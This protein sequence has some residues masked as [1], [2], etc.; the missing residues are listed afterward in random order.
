MNDL[1]QSAFQYLLKT[2][3]SYYIVVIIQMVM[4]NRKLSFEP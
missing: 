3:Q 2:S 1:Y 4:N